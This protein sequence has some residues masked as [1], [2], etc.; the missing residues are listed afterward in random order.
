MF[1][2]RNFMVS[3]I[4]LCM[5]WGCVLT[6]L[7]YMQL[8][9]FPKLLAEKTIFSPLYILASKIIWPWVYGFLC[10]CM[11]SHSVMS[12]CGPMDC[13]QPGSSVYGIFQARKFHWRGLWFLLWGIFLT[14][15]SNRRL[16]FPALAGGFF[17]IAPPTNPM[18]LFM[19]SLFCSIDLY[20]LVPVPHFFFFGCAGSSLPRGLF[21]SFREWG[22]LSSC[23]R[24]TYC[25]GFVCSEAQAAGHMAS[26]LS[27]HGLSSCHSQILEHRLNS[28]GTWA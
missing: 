26:V 16:A 15:G 21:S 12:D 3:C 10:E 19:G 9:S 14:Q 6:S 24:A 25:D 13:S 8:S 20:V 2:F 27:A 17:T 5:V 4:I 18:G 28:C 23:T 22:L 7:I 1:S 11:L